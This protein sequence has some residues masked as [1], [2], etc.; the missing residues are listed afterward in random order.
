MFLCLVCPS[1]QLAVIWFCLW[2]QLPPYSQCSSVFVLGLISEF[3]SAITS[4]RQVER[5]LH[6]GEPW[7]APP[8]LLNVNYIWKVPWVTIWWTPVSSTT[9]QFSRGRGPHLFTFNITWLAQLMLCKFQLNHELTKSAFL[10]V[11]RKTERVPNF[12]L[13]PKTFVKEMNSSLLLHSSARGK[14]WRK[15]KRNYKSLFFIHWSSDWFKQELCMDG[16]KIIRL[17]MAH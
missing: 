17:G 7:P 1:T 12:W 16:M 14:K 4:S 5:P 6:P 13:I 10:P 8:S 11:I 9:L 15:N 3:S 2:A